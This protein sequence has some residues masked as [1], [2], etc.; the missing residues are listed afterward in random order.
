MRL[1]TKVWHSPQIREELARLA[2]DADLNSET[3][4]YAV[5]TRWNTVTEVL[6]RGLQMREVLGQLCDMTAF[7]S[8]KSGGVQLRRYTI[9]D[10]EWVILEQ[11][12][13][14]LHVSLIVL[15][16]YRISDSA[17][18]QPFLYATKIMSKGDYALVHNVIPSM[19]ILTEHLDAFKDDTNL[20]PIIRVAAARGMA[21]MN[22]YYSRTDESEIYRISMSK[23]VACD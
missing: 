21:I 2:G 15:R 9:N 18:W 20:K 23:F 5:R 8:S 17:R 19:D 7:N 10:E 16:R 4:V 14:L 3:L 6:E 12:F 11:L 13:K 22:K 1:S